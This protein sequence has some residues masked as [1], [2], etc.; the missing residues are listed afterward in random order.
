MRKAL[1][2]LDCSADHADDVARMGNVGCG[3]YCKQVC[4]V[5]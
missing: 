5:K 2:G 3:S 4:D 1:T